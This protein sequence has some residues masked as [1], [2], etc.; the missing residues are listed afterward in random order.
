MLL[1]QK[2]TR[3][4]R[5]QHW[6]QIVRACRSSGQTVKVWCEE[7]HINVKTYYHWQKRVCQATCR[8]LSV[9]TEKSLEAVTS[10]QTPVFA[11]VAQSLPQKEN[12]ALT[13]EKNGLSIQ[14]Y[15]GAAV[16]TIETALLA[17]RHLC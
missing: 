2:V 9:E 5:L 13:I 7:H 4:I 10:Y 8:S 1:V 6:S 12:V 15:D 14:I 16:Q 11:E 17:L 3:E